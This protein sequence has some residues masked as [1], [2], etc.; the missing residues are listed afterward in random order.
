MPFGLKNAPV[1]F[2]RLMDQMLNDLLDFTRAYMD[3]LVVFSSTWKEH[4]QHL[5]TLLARFGQ[6]GLTVKPFKCSWATAT[7]TFL[8]HVV[9]HGKVS[10]MDCKVA[11]IRDY[12][13]PDTKTAI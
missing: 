8:G 4:L 10:L 11:A 12:V 3:D 9:G 5:S 2:Q 6:L 1:T 7:C 13:R